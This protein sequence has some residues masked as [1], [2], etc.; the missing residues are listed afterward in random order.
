M[1]RISFLL[2]FSL[3]LVVELFHWDDLSSTYLNANYAFTT[4]AIAALDDSSDTLSMAKDPAIDPATMILLGSGLV[5]L[6]GIGRRK[7]R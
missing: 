4:N 7:D 6:A 5:G 2:A 3:F 1:R